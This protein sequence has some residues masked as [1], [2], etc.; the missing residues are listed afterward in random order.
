MYNIYMIITFL[1]FKFL[2]IVL[3]FYNLQVTSKEHNLEER[4]SFTANI[5]I[6]LPL[7]PILLGLS[8]IPSG[9]TAF[10]SA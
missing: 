6:A 10:S 9:L 1:F 5:L 4:S 2:Y 7:G 3:N 8:C